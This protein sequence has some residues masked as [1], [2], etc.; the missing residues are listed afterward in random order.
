MSYNSFHSIENMLGDAWH[1]A[2]WKVMEEAGKEERRIAL[3]N[4]QIDEQ[5]NVWIT[6]YLDGGWSHRSYGHNYN[7]AS[8]VVSGQMLCKMFIDQQL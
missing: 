2:L 5:G 7:A 1:D 3:E 4:N 6:V 8:G